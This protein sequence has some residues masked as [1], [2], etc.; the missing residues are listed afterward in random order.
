M[1]EPKQPLLLQYFQELPQRRDNETTGTYA[2]RFRAG[3]KRYK[4]L[5]EERYTE[6]T[7]Y[8][9][10]SSDFAEIRR[11]AVLA[12]GMLGSMT[13]NE[14]LADMLHDD[15]PNVRQFAGDALWSLWFRA[16]APENNQEL[17]HLV[18][19]SLEGGDSGE[20]LVEF[21]SLLQKAPH[22]AE[23]FNQRAVF[24]FR[25]GDYSKAIAD[26]QRVLRLNPYHFG[27]ASGLAQCYLKQKK[28]R[29]A[30]RTYRRTLSLNPNLENVR[31][32]I[33]SLEKLLGEEGRK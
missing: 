3:M 14:A 19:K 9:L 20:I 1:S 11:A 12:L 31:E 25:R 4:K 33:E 17:Q 10:L 21:E 5:V 27:A 23:A 2:R 30:L 8:R 29:A 26:C 18:R 13:V 6:A 15:D 32:A 16:D 28:Y 7:L 24:H 22:F